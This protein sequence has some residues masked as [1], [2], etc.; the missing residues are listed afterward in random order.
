MYRTA[1]RCT[2]LPSIC[3]RATNATPALRRKD[4]FMEGDVVE[5]LCRV[6]LTED[7]DAEVVRHVAAALGS[8]AYGSPAHLAAVC[9]RP[10]VSALARWLSSD[11][12]DVMAACAQS[13]KIMF[14]RGEPPV[15]VL[16]DA[17][18]GLMAR[19]VRCLSKASHISMSATALLA[20]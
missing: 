19:L 11:S 8:L 7:E 2:A 5:R 9:R 20:A 15:D 10:C 12:E 17:Q 1:P 16:V 6:L 3:H 4:V 18:P 14:Q 13:L